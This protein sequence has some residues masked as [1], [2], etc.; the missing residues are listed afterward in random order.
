VPDSLDPLLRVVRVGYF[1]L[2]LGA[3]LFFFVW[4][5]GKPRSAFAARGRHVLRNVALFVLM[6]LFADVLVGDLLLGLKARLTAAPDGLLSPLGWPWPVLAVVGLLAIDLACYLYHRLSHRVRWLWLLH[7]THHTD[8][9]LDVS[10]ALRFH[11]V[12]MAFYVAVIAGTLLALGIPLWVAGVRALFVNPQFM[13]QHANVRFPSW[14]ERGFAWLL[15][16]PAIHHVHHSALRAQTDANYG[17]MFSLWDRAFGTY[18]AP[19]A[20]DPPLIGVAGHT[21]DRWQSVLGM[22]ATPWH[23]R[24]SL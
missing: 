15:V 22:L 4:E 7:A 8:P 19:G 12:D 9:H 1:G 17:Q 11:P 21:D 14:I 16:T 5:G 13:L 20:E 24:S 18:R 6:V 23:G 2:T 3:F 10:T